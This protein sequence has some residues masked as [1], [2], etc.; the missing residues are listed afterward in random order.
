MTRIRGYPFFYMIALAL[1]IAAFVSFSQSD[2]EAQTSPQISPSNSGPLAEALALGAE[3]YEEG[4]VVC[5]LDGNHSEAEL[6]LKGAA[7]LSDTAALANV[8]HSGRQ[9]VRSTTE[10]EKI[11]VMPAFAF[12]SNSDLAALM[13]WLRVKFDGNEE[14]LVT[15]QEAA[16]L[17]ELQ[18]K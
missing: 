7:I 15:E 16:T 9:T 12:L 8:I 6:R 14:G 2:V 5:H 13:T 11:S 17:R 3:V 10:G 18:T 1:G 4:C